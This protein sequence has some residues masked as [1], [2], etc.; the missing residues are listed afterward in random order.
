MTLKELHEQYQAALKAAKVICDAAEKDDREFTAE[1]RQ[2]LTGYMEEAKSLKVQ[3]K[4]A[5][6]DAAVR[7]TVAELG[8]EGG[9]SQPDPHGV[10]KWQ[11]LGERFVEA[12]A[13]KAWM[14]GFPG[15]VIPETKK[16][17]NSPVVDVGDVLDVLGRKAVVTG[18]SDTSAGV[19]VETDH[20]GIYEP[21][22]RRPLTVLDLVSQRP[23]ASDLVDFVRQTVQA[24][25]A[26]PVAEANVTTYA[27]A[28]G[29]VSGEKPE[30]TIGFERVQAAVKT[31]P[32]WIPAT[33]RALSDAAQIRSLIDQELRADVREELEDQ[34]I[35]GNGVGENMTGLMYTSGV[36]AQAWDTDVLVTTRKALTTLR[37]IGRSSP[38]A[39]VFNPND[40]ETIDLLKDLE[41]RYQ[42][43]GPL[44]EG[45]RSLW[46]IPVVES[47][48]VTE[49]TGLLGD[50][51]KAVLWTRENATIS[52]SDSHEDFFIRNMVAILC[53]MRA[54]FGVIRPS[55][56]VQVDLISGS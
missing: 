17:I 32:V 30:A 23:T 20:T 3:L 25:Q 11:T 6:D 43:G 46:G 55:A 51:R 52:V 26:A 33:K 15:G 38:T 39:W 42:F 16:G 24:R 40:W 18:S 47:E 35:T 19:F 4:Q 22:G 27:G 36:L 45:T 37:T 28:T 29:E 49:G 44:R 9:I 53:E 48:A 8:G 10:R 34:I 54:A 41:G 1:E 2:K 56:F 50:W 21:L 5:E 31:I 14:K 12:E 7:A 13:F